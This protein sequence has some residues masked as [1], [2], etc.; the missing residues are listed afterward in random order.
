MDAPLPGPEALGLLVG[1][2]VVVATTVLLR[3]AVGRGAVTDRGAGVLVVLGLGWQQLNKP[4][5]GVVLWVVTPSHGLVLADLVAAPAA[6]IVA[7]HVLMRLRGS[8]QAG[9]VQPA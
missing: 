7:G 4:I 6:A 9:A 3:Q 5:E 2:L 1:L 8:V